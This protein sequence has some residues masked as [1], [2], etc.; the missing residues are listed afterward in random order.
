VSVIDKMGRSTRSEDIALARSQGLDVDDDNE[1]AP[2][3][4][5]AAGAR[6]DNT[7]SLHGQEWG[8]AGTCH[9]KSKYPTDIDPQ[10]LN[11]SRS[12]LCTQ[13]KLD[14]FFIILSSQLYRKCYCERN[15]PYTSRTSTQYTIDGRV[16]ALPWFFFF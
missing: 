2:E 11:Y 1:T 10:I 16:C 9:R 14:M 15:K 13:T 8:W 4:I 12:D 6:I 5:P 3:N 7:T